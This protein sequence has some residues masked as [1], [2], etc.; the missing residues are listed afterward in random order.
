MEQSK[1]SKN[2]YRCILSVG[3][4][5]LF[6]STSFGFG[7]NQHQIIAWIA[8]QYMDQDVRETVGDLLG[9]QGVESFMAVSTWA[10]EIRGDSRYN[11]AYPYHYVNIAQNSDVY[12]RKRDC[13]QDACIVEAVNRYSKVLTQ[14]SVRDSIKSE[15]L[16]FVIH[17][18]GDIHQPLHAGFAE[19]RGGNDIPVLLNGEVTNLHSAWDW[20]ILATQSFTVSAYADSLYR[21][22]TPTNHQQWSNLS[23]GSWASESFQLSKHYVYTV[24]AG[25]T[26]TTEYVG[27]GIGILDEQIKRAGVRLAALLNERLGTEHSTY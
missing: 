16:K 4:L 11:Y 19:D 20:G 2:V 7:Y 6:H 14:P 15:A 1:I 9:E 25:E 23:A 24:E 12:D 27:R 8:W 5:F 22:I 18:A 17:F 3:I 10:D 26:L 21:T 13:P